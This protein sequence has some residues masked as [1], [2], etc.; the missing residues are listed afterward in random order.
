MLTVGARRSTGIQSSRV[1]H[2][3]RICA[4]Y[5]TASFNVDGASGNDSD[6]IVNTSNQQSERIPVTL[7]EHGVL[8]V[9]NCCHIYIESLF[10]FC[11]IDLEERFV[12]GKRNTPK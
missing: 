4:D 7:K 1:W 8:A 5:S 11:L 6:G 9:F 10:R 12:K 2:D 3:S